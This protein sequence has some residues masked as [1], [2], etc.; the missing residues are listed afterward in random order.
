MEDITV[1]QL[2]AKMDNNEDF[3]LIDVREPHEAEAFNIGA[4]LI[5]LGTLQAALPEL[6]EIKDKEIVVHCRS[7]AR[8]ANAKQ[9][10]LAAG[11]TKVSNLLGGMLAWQD[12]YENAHK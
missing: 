5:P 3:I 2:K 6:E 11:F 8:S 1:A 9:I 7:G 4:R 12:A 10:L